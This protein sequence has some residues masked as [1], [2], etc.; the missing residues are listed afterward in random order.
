VS[1]ESDP[2]A[3]RGRLDRS[4]SVV[5]RPVALRRVVL[6]ITGESFA[7]PA[8]LKQVTRDIVAAARTGCQ[9]AVVVGGGNILRG[10]RT[11]LI[12]RIPADCAGM[13]ATIVNGIILEQ[14]LARSLPTRHLSAF[15]V[16][17][18]VPRYNTRVARARLA[19]GEV[20]VLSGGTGKPLFSTDTAA[21][22]RARE[23]GAEAILKATKVKG[24]YSADPAENPDA[25]FYPRLTFRQALQRKLAIM[26]AAAFAQCARHRIPII[27]FDLFQPG[28]IARVVKGEPIG[29]KVC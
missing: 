5:S 12:A 8:R 27:V 4:R 11:D 6:K 3:R 22:L 28:N 20:L 2:D 17:G 23:L 16:A 25:R 18:I 14:L 15:G 13:V 7:P 21:A 29:S 10:A 24:V 26:D 19:R 1:K 9:V